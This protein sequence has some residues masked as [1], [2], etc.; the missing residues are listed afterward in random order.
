MIVSNRD[1]FEYDES[2][3]T[4]FNEDTSEDGGL[5]FVFSKDDCEDV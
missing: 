3:A 1:S 4:V 5:L 2:L